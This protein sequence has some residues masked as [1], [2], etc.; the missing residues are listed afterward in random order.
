MA[1]HLALIVERRRCLQQRCDERRADL[2]QAIHELHDH[3]RPV[4]R[5]AH[6]VKRLAVPGVLLGGLGWRWFHMVPRVA[7][8][9][10][11]TARVIGKARYLL[12]LIGL[13]R[14]TRGKRGRRGR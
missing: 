11:T 5:A 2:V 10:M 13:G 3:W 9:V 1:R 12:P 8:G 4:E 6:K 7:R 14:M